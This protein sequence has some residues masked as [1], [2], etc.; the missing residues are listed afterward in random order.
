LICDEAIVICKK[1]GC[2]RSSTLSY[3]IK[4]FYYSLYN[5]MITFYGSLNQIDW[6]KVLDKM[7]NI[8]KIIKD[9]FG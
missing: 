8:W 1:E 4:I 6:C 5:K 3:F 9:I 2:T 7:L